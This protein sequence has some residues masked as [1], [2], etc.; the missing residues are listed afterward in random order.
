MLFNALFPIH[1]LSCE[2]KLPS[3]LGEEGVSSSLKNLYWS[4]TKMKVDQE[5]NVFGK[6]LRT[7]LHAKIF[8]KSLFWIQRKDISLSTEL[9]SSH[10]MH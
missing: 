5:T 9:L 2:L 7:Q 10:F 1:L 3:I 4:I 8:L 6:E